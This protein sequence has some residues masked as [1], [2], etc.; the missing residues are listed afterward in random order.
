MTE[1]EA[2]LNR[3]LGFDPTDTHSMTLMGILRFGQQRFDEAL[4]LLSRAA[5]RDPDNSETQNY[6]GI[7]LSHKGQRGAAETA[8]RRAVQLTP[9]YGGAHQNLAIIYATQQ[10]PFK[11]LARW[12]YQKSLA[13]GHPANPEV[14][15]LIEQDASSIKAE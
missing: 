9:N 7:T 10:P 8:L 1:A 12:H 6:L 14:E 15:K 4:D 13:T 11:E 5:Q 3:A 2:H